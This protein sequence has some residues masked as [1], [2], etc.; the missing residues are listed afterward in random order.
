MAKSFSSH[1]FPNAKPVPVSLE[2]LRLVYRLVRL[3]PTGAK[4]GPSHIATIISW[5]GHEIQS[6]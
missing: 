3:N 4:R 2:V 1:T 6:P 5:R